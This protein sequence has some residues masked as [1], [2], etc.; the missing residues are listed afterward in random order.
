MIKDIVKWIKEY[1]NDNKLESLVIGVSGGIDS[2]VVSTLCA[3]TGIKTFVIGMPIH[4]KKDQEVL[5]DRHIIWLSEKFENVSILKTDL[6]DV[7]TCFMENLKCK[8]GNEYEDKHA[9][10]NTRSRL[11]MMTLYHIA[12]V[13]KGIVVGTG[14]KVEDF[15]VG[16]FTKYG[17]GGVDISPIADLYKSQ[18]YQIG[19]E[20]GII[21]EIIDAAPTDGLWEDGRTDEDQLGMKYKDFEWVMKE[22][23]TKNNPTIEENKKINAYL[24]FNKKNKHKMEKIPIFYLTK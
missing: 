12:T 20:L 17:D 16:F 24:S 5:S 8:F 18:V 1:T 14:N 7:F 4:Q 22:G 21:Q 2:A 6:T 13:N 10:A 11:R 19:K 3:M 9:A 15:G 23:L